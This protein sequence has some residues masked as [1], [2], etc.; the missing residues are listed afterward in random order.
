MATQESAGQQRD[1]QGR[2]IVYW[3]KLSVAKKT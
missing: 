1:P 3:K 2:S